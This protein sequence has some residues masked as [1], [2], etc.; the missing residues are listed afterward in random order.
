MMTMLPLPSTA[1]RIQA[2]PHMYSMGT[3]YVRRIVVSCKRATNY[4]ASLVFQDTGVKSPLFSFP[5]F[6]WPPV[7]SSASEPFLVLVFFGEGVAKGRVGIS[8]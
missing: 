7:P 1:P 2:L 6:P 8:K 3:P 4:D 5:Q